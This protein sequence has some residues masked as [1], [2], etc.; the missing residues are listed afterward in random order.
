MG[1]KRRPEAYSRIKAFNAVG[2]ICPTATSWSFDRMT[3]NY[4]GKVLTVYNGSIHREDFPGGCF[5][6]GSQ[7]TLVGALKR[8]ADQVKEF[9]AEQKE[10][11]P[12]APVP[13]A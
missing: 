4:E 10:V 3:H 6:A 8:L 7:T 9:E 13:K 2:K 1:T 11:V 12:D 5:V